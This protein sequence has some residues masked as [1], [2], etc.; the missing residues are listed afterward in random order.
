MFKFLF[1]FSTFLSVSIASAT[2]VTYQNV[3]LSYVVA[4]TLPACKTQCTVQTEYLKKLGLIILKVEECSKDHTSDWDN[5][6][7]DNYGCRITFVH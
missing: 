5:E 6:N 2:N 7:G 1:I 3:P 4:P